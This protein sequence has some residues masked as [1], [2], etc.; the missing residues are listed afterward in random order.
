MDFYTAA[1]INKIAEQVRKH[2]GYGDDDYYVDITRMAN[3]GGVEVNEVEFD[4]PE[5]AGMLITKNGKQIIN[6]NQED[7]EERKRFTIAHEIAH[8][9]LHPNTTSAMHIDYRQA[10]K[11]YTNE[12][13]LTREIQANMLAAAL[14]MP[15][16]LVRNAWDRLKD[17][18]D[19]ADLFKV[20]KRAAAIRLESLGLL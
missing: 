14:L 7:S 11:N 9:I 1:Q 8:A 12:S 2:F 4:D 19:V 13:E 17:V 10:L 6:I 18:D 16:R 5:V 3:N 20:S 15:V